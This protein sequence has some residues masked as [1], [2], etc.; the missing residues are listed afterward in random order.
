MKKTNYFILFLLFLNL[1]SP[2][3]NAARLSPK[4]ILLGAQHLAQKTYDGDRQLLL[5]LALLAPSIDNGLQ[6]AGSAAKNGIKNWWYSTS[7]DA[8]ILATQGYAPTEASSLLFKTLFQGVRITTEIPINFIKSWINFLNCL[9][10]F[11]PGLNPEASLSHWVFYEKWFKDASIP[12]PTPTPEANLKNYHT[13]DSEH[14]FPLISNDFTIGLNEI[15]GKKVIDKKGF[16]GNFFSIIHA[17]AYYGF[18]I[19]ESYLRQTIKLFYFCITNPTFIL[20]LGIML[21]AALCEYLKTKPSSRPAIA[22]P[23]TRLAPPEPITEGKTTTERRAV[24]IEGWVEEREQI[25]RARFYRGIATNTIIRNT[26]LRN[27]VKKR[28][29]RLAQQK[30]IWQKIRAKIFLRKLFKKKRLKKQFEDSIPEMLQALQVTT[31]AYRR[32]P[33]AAPTEDGTSLAQLGAVA[34][35]GASTVAKTVL[36]EH[37][38]KHTEPVFVQ[39]TQQ[40]PTG[41]VQAPS[42]HTVKS[43]DDDDYATQR[44]IAQASSTAVTAVDSAKERINTAV[45]SAKERINTAVDSAKERINTA[46]D[47]AKERARDAVDAAATTPA[48]EKLKRF[49]RKFKR[50]HTPAAQAAAQWTQETGIPIAQEAAS[51][52]WDGLKADL[53]R[54]RAE[55]AE[56][57]RFRA[58]S[59]EQQEAY[60][61]EHKKIEA[62]RIRQQIAANKRKLI[63][64]L[65]CIPVYEVADKSPRC[66]CVGPEEGH[67]DHVTVYFKRGKTT[68]WSTLIPDITLTDLNTFVGEP[69][70]LLLRRQL[71][72]QTLFNQFGKL[73]SSRE[74]TNRTLGDLVDLRDDESSPGIYKIINGPRGR[75]RRIKISNPDELEAAQAKIAFLNAQQAASKPSGLFSWLG[76]KK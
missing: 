6:T 7:T 39:V 9:S 64:E 76:K 60:R 70:T 42:V 69:K 74:D 68:K 2:V 27:V 33:L 1:G 37:A 30:A 49:I 52:L 46:V 35:Q 59:P 11:I 15:N 4:E 10:G 21:R 28:R 67:P 25:R 38:S 18:A 75:L 63:Q 51:T 20:S 3:V 32:T 36:G 13:E 16:W 44:I 53:A 8:S 29:N 66:I 22:I 45:D 54:R 5:V 65:P 58:M 62:E 41:L 12:T 40:S 31:L 72:K 47:S 71:E 50:D 34:A 55:K 43:D 19:P 56:V 14:C 26:F 24:L 48:L 61:E 57:E 23:P 17:S 73:L